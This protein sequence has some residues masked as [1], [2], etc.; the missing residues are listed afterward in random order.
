MKK[1]IKGLLIAA[2]SVTVLACGS[3]TP[4]SDLSKE[5]QASVDSTL[6][7]D[8]AI[9]DSME[10]ALNNVLEAD[11]LTGASEGHDHHHDHGGEEHSH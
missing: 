1:T 11:S 9:M 10:R 8:Q 3:E 2:I 7:N 4:K 6:S 5:E